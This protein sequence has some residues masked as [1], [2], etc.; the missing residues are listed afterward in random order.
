MFNVFYIILNI[1]C[2]FMFNSCAYFFIKNSI[3]VKPNIKF[4][5]KIHGIS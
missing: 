5:S 3:T 2:V 4:K 1:K